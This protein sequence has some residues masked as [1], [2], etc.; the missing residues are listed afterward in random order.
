MKLVDHFEACMIVGLIS[1]VLLF[2][3]FALVLIQWRN[4]WVEVEAKLPVTLKEG[5]TYIIVYDRP[6]STPGNNQPEY[7]YQFS[8]AQDQQHPHIMVKRK[9]LNAD[10]KIKVYEL[11]QP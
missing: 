10:L 9:N 11:T 1:S 7:G 6:V 4:E 5:C 3:I 2:A 8:P